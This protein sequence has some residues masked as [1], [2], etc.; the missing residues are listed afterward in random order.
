M[1][2]Y[3]IDYD[4]NK[5]LTDVIPQSDTIYNIVLAANTEQTITVPSGATPGA[6]TP[7]VTFCADAS[8]G[9]CQAFTFDMTV[10]APATYSMA[11]VNRSP[12]YAPQLPQTSP[13]TGWTGLHVR[14]VLQLEGT[15][16]P[17]LAGAVGALADAKLALHA[18]NVPS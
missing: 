18:K 1:K 5:L 3:L 8:G 17:S 6:Y 15:I 11:V 12:I 13:R 10:V 16:G 9:S 2:N 14:C 4:A 7:S